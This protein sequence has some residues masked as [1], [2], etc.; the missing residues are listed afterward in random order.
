MRTERE[1]VAFVLGYDMIHDN[2][3]RMECTCDDAFEICTG[4]AD[5]FLSSEF[6][7]PNKDLY[8]CLQEY[9]EYWA[10]N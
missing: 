2:L 7:N 8:T 10:N 4:I 5:E 9:V 6:N 3:D 1:Y